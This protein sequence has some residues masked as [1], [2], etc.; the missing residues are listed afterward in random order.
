MS[1]RQFLAVGAAAA[2][3]MLTTVTPA[4]AADHTMKTEDAAPGGVMKFTHLG[5]LLSVCDVESDGWAVIGRVYVHNRNGTHGRKI[6]SRQ[7][8]GNDGRCKIGRASM[9]GR[10]N[11]REGREYTFQVCLHNATEDKYCDWAVWK[12]Y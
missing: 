4:A 11:L 12:N 6:Y 7:D 10:Y 5:D 3:F 9:G 8:G 1:K 2:A